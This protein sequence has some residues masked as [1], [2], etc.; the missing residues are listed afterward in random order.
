MNSRRAALVA[1]VCA[2]VI[3][4]AVSLPALTAGTATRQRSQVWAGASYAPLPAAAKSGVG[5]SLEPLPDSLASA[6]QV[7]VPE[8]IS[9]A[10]ERLGLTA[11]EASDNTV[12]V[13]SF[14]DDEYTSANATGANA[15]GASAL[16]ADNL[17]AYVV[18]FSG[19]SVSSLG[20]GVGVHTQESVVVNATSG[21]VVEVYSIQ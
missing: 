10:Q 7:T 21:D 20:R 3:A 18:T 8:A 17:P 5:V 9:A 11:A 19:L 13:G 1:S 14:T 2:A 6:V 12:L 4:F 15:A 16:V